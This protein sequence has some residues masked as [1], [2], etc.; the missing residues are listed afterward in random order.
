V[1]VISIPDWGATPFA[2]GKDKKKIAKEIDAFNKAKKAITEK[3]KVAFIDITTEQRAD[4]N[5]PAYVAP[6]KLH[7]SAA[8]YAKWARAV[9]EK[10]TEHLRAK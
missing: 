6:D 5:D 8:E 9:A 1:F 4:S 2:E 7:P 10:I 3:Y